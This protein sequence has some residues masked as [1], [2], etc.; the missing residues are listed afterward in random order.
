MCL[1]KQV[2]SWIKDLP[3]LTKLELEITM[4]EEVELI[5]VLGE[6]KEL[7]I[8]RLCVKPLQDADGKLDF[9]VWVNGIQQRCYLNLK[10]LEITCSSKLNVSFGSEAMQNLELLTARC[11][12][13]ST[14]K[15]TEIKNLSKQKLNEVRLIG[16]HDTA[17]K[18][19]IEKQLEEHPRNPPLKL[20]ELEGR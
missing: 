19:D 18:D 13:G 4:S 9:C 3:K 5:N 15:F 2:P 11:C 6:T 7:C 20:E 8:L 16:S 1:V 10:I 12:S 17:L 14:L